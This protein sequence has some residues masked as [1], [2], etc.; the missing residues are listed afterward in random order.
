[1]TVGIKVKIAKDVATACV[2]KCIKDFYGEYPGQ[3]M[4]SDLNEFVNHDV[5]K[6]HN[7]DIEFVEFVNIEFELWQVLLKIWKDDK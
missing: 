1:M 3:E 5:V 4:P 7:M 2:E 6:I